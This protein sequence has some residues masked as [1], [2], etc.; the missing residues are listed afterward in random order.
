MLWVNHTSGARFYVNS[1]QQIRQIQE[2]RIKTMVANSEIKH[3]IKTM[4]EVIRAVV[5]D[6]VF[7]FL[8][9]D[10]VYPLQKQPPEVFCKKRCS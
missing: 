10:K 3:K 5:F 4:L 1:T 7:A 6:F 9:Y 8:L 2:K